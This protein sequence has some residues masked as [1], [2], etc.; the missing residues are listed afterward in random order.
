MLSFRIWCCLNTKKAFSP[1]NTTASDP[2][3]AASRLAER[4]PQDL[5]SLHICPFPKGVKASILSGCCGLSQGLFS[6]LQQALIQQLWSFPRRLLVTCNEL[7]SAAVDSFMPLLFIC[8]EVL[9][10]R[11]G[12]IQG[13]ILS[14]AT[15]SLS[16]FVDSLKPFFPI[17]PFHLQRAQVLT[18]LL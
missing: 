16:A 14:S 3:A 4:R 13:S 11:C 6:H 9:T 5:P 8:N 2:R 7:S 17:A 1:H 15:T 12:L 10:S 18:L